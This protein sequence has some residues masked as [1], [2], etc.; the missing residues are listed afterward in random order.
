MNSF[1]FLIVFEGGK[2]CLAL[3]ES[4]SI[5]TWG[6]PRYGKLGRSSVSRFEK[7]NYLLALI[8]FLII[9]FFC[10]YDYYFQFSF[11]NQFKSKIHS[12]FM[13]R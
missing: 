10:F 6:D 8:F 3:T 13:W 1:G 11:G 2:F 12:H 7:Q 5:L 4:G 9:I